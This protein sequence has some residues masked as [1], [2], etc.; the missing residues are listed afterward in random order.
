MSTPVC[1]NLM[2]SKNAIKFDKLH[3]S[4][5]PGSSVNVLCHYWG[6]TRHSDAVH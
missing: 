4:T 2:P 6:T 5:G 3:N 1:A